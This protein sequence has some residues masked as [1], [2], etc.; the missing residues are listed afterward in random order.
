MMKQGDTFKVSFR[1]GNKQS[2]GQADS[3]GFASSAPMSDYPEV[4]AEYAKYKNM[5]GSNE[6]ES[7]DKTMD[8]Q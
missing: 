3:H 6:P 5:A 8:E 1:P 2:F 7:Q 4:E